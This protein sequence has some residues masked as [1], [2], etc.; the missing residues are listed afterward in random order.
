MPPNHAFP[1][2]EKQGVYNA[3]YKRRDVRG[4]F[5]PYPIPDELLQKVLDAAHH[6]GSVGFMQPW[7]FVVVRSREIKQKVKEL[8]ER[9]NQQAAKVFEDERR[10][11]YSRLKLEGILE[12][13][14][15]ICVTCDPARHGPHVLGRHTQRQTDIYSTCCA[16]QNLW[17]AAR[18]EGIGMGW[19]S[20]FDPKELQEVLLIPEHVIPVAYLCMGYVSE[21][22]SQPELEAAGWLQR[23]PLK[24]LIFYDQ[25]GKK[26]DQ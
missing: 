16:I 23:L 6:A 2:V 25:W 14:V 19:V 9:A 17:L 12:S 11:L 18:A 15:N 13:P 7:S 26:D 5:L 20:I 8:F 3:I 10:A 4:Q 22:L 1:E 24:E 21:F